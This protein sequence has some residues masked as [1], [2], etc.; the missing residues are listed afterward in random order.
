LKTSYDVVVGSRKSY[1]PTTILILLVELTMGYCT[2]ST[3]FQASAKQGKTLVLEVQ[4][5]KFV[6]MLGVLWFKSRKWL[7]TH[8]LQQKTRYNIMH[9]YLVFFNTSKFF[10]QIYKFLDWS[11]HHIL[12]IEKPSC[13]SMYIS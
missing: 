10:F 3:P 8:S 5:G 6:A 11:H 4:P 2:Q 7:A 13:C 12:T 9:M 1:K